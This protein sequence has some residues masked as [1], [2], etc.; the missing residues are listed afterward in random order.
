[1]KKL[2]TVFAAVML[3]G[4]GTIPPPSKGESLLVVWHPLPLAERNIAC[5]HAAAFSIGCYRMIDGVCHI[6]TPVPTS[7]S[8]YNTHETMGHELRHCFAGDFH[9]GFTPVVRGRAR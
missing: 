1:M 4:C 8:D 9:D 7:D 6:F 3:A 5:V 2:M